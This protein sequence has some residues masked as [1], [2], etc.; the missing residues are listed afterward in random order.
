METENVIT[1]LFIMAAML[2]LAHLA[3]MKISSYFKNSPSQRR[4]HD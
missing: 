1:F 4:H 3:A 2:V